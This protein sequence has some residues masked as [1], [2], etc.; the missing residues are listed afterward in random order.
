MDSYGGFSPTYP[1]SPNRK[2]LR[3][4]GGY[5]WLDGKS[6]GDL[7]F[8]ISASQQR[9]RKRFKMMLRKTNDRNHDVEWNDRISIITCSSFF[10]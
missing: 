5:P 2:T 8:V 7:R 3:A 10:L 6:P 1:P 9:K 4:S